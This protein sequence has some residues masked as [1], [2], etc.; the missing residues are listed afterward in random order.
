MTLGY[1]YLPYCDWYLLADEEDKNRDTKKKKSMV[2]RAK[3]VLSLSRLAFLFSFF[4]YLPLCICS[5]I[6][7]NLFYKI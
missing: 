1:K 7:S 6:L 4:F 2:D 5:S 3:T